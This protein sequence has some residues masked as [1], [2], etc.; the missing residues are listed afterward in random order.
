M[1]FQ[2]HDDMVQVEYMTVL[3]SSM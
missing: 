3:N 2:I 1:T